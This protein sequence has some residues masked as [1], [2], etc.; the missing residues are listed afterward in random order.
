MEHGGR[1]S[2]VV[3]SQCEAMST[4]QRISELT[5]SAQALDEALRDKERG[6]CLPALSDGRSLLL[7]QNRDVTYRAVW[8]AVQH[9]GGLKG[10]LILAWIGHGITL[11]G[12]FYALPHDSLSLPGHPHGPY[13]LTQHIKELLSH[14][15]DLELLVLIDACSAGDAAVQAAGW[16]RLNQDGRRHFQVLTASNID[17]PAWDCAFTRAASALLHS[18][19]IRAEDLLCPVD[20]KRAAERASR[21]QQ[22]VLVAWDG[23]DGPDLWVSRNAALSRE[24]GSVL[25]FSSA[26]LPLLRA[27]LQHFRPPPAL[28]ELVGAMKQHP[29]TV[30]RGP[31]GC[32]KTTLL[33]ALCRPEVSAGAVPAG[34][35]HGLRLLRLHESAAAVAGDLARQLSVTVKGFKAA[36]ATFEKEATAKGQELPETERALLGPLGLLPAGTVVRLALDGFD[37]LSDTAAAELT[38]LIDRLRQPLRGSTDVRLMVST[39]TGATPPP[40]D[41]EVS[42][43]TASAAEVH[44]Y[45]DAQHIPGSLAA[46]IVEGS[47]GSWLVASLLADHARATPGLTPSQV[48]QGLAAIF[49]Q[50]FETSL[51]GSARWEADDCP[52]RALFTVLAAAGPGAV[53]P[54]PLLFDACTRLGAPGMTESWLRTRLPAPLRRFVVRAPTAESDTTAVLY[55]LFHQSLADYLTSEAPALGHPYAVDVRAAHRS[56]AEAIAELAPVDQRTPV[57]AH[58]PLQEY[59]DRAEPDHL[60]HAGF[61]LEALGSLEAREA[62]LSADNLQRWQRWQ[63]EARRTLGP[64]HPATLTARGNT[65]YWTGDVGNAARALELFTT[66]L[67]DLVRVLGPDHLETLGAR[68]NVAGWAGETG[69]A[70]RASALFTALGPDLARLFGADHPS[71]LGVRSQAARWTGETGDAAAAA[72]LYRALLPDR[73]RVLGPDHPDTLATRSNIAYWT[74]QAGDARGALELF[75]ALLPDRTRVLGT[76]HPDTLATR[77]DAA[78]WTGEVEG[79]GPALDLYGALFPDM[80]RALGKDHSHTLTVHA[81]IATWTGRAG[82]AREAVEQLTM[83]LPDR[84]RVLGADHPDTLATRDAIVRWTEKAE[85]ERAPQEPEPPESA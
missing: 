42:V 33:S 35:L 4:T 72:E 63:D 50:R 31:A 61:H 36:H 17:E 11:N 1:F 58:H 77:S 43:D 24:A 67:P 3:A 8:E 7:D 2:L 76:D 73:V 32:G 84:V 68:S 46:A 13:H 65:A 66:L 37:Q 40:A 27:G 55:G 22:P 12:D 60:W 54:A 28:A 53:L 49:H 44:A 79:P 6:A 51:E 14:T 5:E 16:A 15:P 74:G 82:R 10:L 56:I 19:D 80:V 52:E 85:A 59:A 69:D 62:P 78:A 39:R 23:T 21:A 34:F 29:Y 70:P 9:V 18:G 41:T 47:G 75:T 57:T 30:V 81:N 64:D 83:L 20:L 71:T 38:D 48:P 26:D 45:L 25:A